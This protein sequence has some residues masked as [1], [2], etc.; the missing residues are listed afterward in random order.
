MRA[1]GTV[2]L[3]HWGRDKIAAIFQTTL[4]NAFSWQKMLEF[5]LKFHLSFPKGTIDNVLGLVQ[6]MAWRRPGDE[7]FSEVMMVSLLRP[8][9]VTW[10]QWVTRKKHSPNFDNGFLW[11]LLQYYIEPSN[12]FLIGIMGLP[13]PRGGLYIERGP[14]CRRPSI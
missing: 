8:I 11:S 12:D 1:T 13:L 9:C 5:R 4:S 6:I 2:G 10:S 7:P 14:L 3:T